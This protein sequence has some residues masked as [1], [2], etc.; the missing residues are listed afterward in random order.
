MK[1]DVPAGPWG[2][3]IE[4]PWRG[5]EKGDY[6]KQMY[7]KS[8]AKLRD[9]GLTSFS[10]IPTLRISG[11]QNRVPQIDF[12]EADR[13]MADAQSG[14]LQKRGHSITTTALVASTII[15]WMKKP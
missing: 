4:L 15:L 13:E 5:D 2:S 7:R 10:G 12:A 1:L 3:N 11:W 6:E 14:R 9:Y 8:L